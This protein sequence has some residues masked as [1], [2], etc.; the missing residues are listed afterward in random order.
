VL[1][2]HPVANGATDEQWRALIQTT[3]IRIKSQDDTKPW[4]PMARRDFLNMIELTCPERMPRLFET[5]VAA[6]QW[7]AGQHEHE[8]S[9]SIEAASQEGTESCSHDFP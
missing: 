4:G 5:H 1:V 6:S 2:E 3:G 8:P 7:L 9:S